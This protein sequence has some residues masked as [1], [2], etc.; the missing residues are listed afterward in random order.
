MTTP[1]LRVDP[2]LRILHRNGK[3]FAG[4]LSGSTGIRPLGTPDLVLLSMFLAPAAPGEAAER[5]LGGPRSSLL[6]VKPPLQHVVA[7]IA[8]L[9]HAG[10]LVEAAASAEADDRPA[11]TL[12]DCESRR[13][14]DGQAYF[15]L[16]TNFMLCPAA[17]GFAINASG[18]RREHVLGI[19]LALL[20]IS[21][22][23]GRSV[24]E[25]VAG[26]HGPG[27]P[28][29]RLQA[30][31]WLIAEGL[32][33][34]GRLAEAPVSAGDGRP[35]GE[36]RPPG[37]AAWEKMRPD[38]RIPVYF[39]PHMENHYPLALGM[40]ASALRAHAGGDLL[41]RFQ[42]L[43]ITYL[44]PEALINGP[45]RRFGPGVWLFS[46]YMWSLGVNLEI[47]TAIKRLDARNL[48]IH[49]GPST[50]NYE[51]A[52]RDFFARHGS[53][54]IAVHGEGEVA[55]GETFECLLRAADGAIRFD[56]HR[57]AQ[58]AG[59][60]YR[61]PGDAA[62]VRSTAPRRRLRQLDAL[63]SPYLEGEFDDYA[64]R[65]EAAIVET[66]RGCPFACTFCDWG[67][68][69]N[70][71]IAK[72]AHGR[73]RDEIE[74]IGRNKVRVLWI[75][76]AN[77]GMF[78]ADVE[79][80]AWVVEVKRRFGYPQEVVVNYTKNA[81][82]RLADIIRTFSTAGIVSQGI[83]SIQTTDA[84]TL[85]IIDRQNIKT[86][87]Y[88]E[89]LQV[90][91]DAGLPLST[92]L[93][94]GLPGATVESFARDLQRYIDVDV[95]VKAYPTQLLPNSPMAAPDYRARYRIEVDAQDFVVSCH[96]FTREDL[97]RMKA[98]NNVYVATEGYA[99]LRYVYRYL[100][101]DHGIPAMTLMQAINDLASTDPDRYPAI[102]WVA[103]YFAGNKCMPGGWR[104]FFDEIAAFVEASWSIGRTP[105][106]DVVLRANEAA[107]P[108]E[109]ITYPL[110]L[111]LSHDIVAWFRAHNV[112]GPV[113]APC[114][115]EYPPGRFVVDDPDGMV[116]IDHEFLQY[117]SHQYFWELHS[118]IS[119]TRSAAGLAA[120]VP[121]REPARMR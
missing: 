105:A 45:Y 30:V 56:P 43:P 60:S 96:S 88:D 86:A 14:P 19:E 74:W 69:T 109:A 76:D 33:V 114:L 49:G 1:L 47:S 29:V 41:Q 46:N 68:A 10:V 32:L 79:F 89:L 61:D 118:P 72:F 100:Q 82:T 103:K 98:L 12:G 67:S 93:M 63:P 8:Q 65:V 102:T 121:A 35:G 24:A 23:A 91:A 97:A 11:R 119:R 83:I 50:P 85:K 13:P 57:L 38:G 84:D 17:A 3:F 44:T 95:S 99:A 94:I 52:C 120:Q 36:A 70:G 26:L 113:D 110:V 62:T 115:A 80:A 22:A 81:T 71:K 101:W 58:V 92:D 25:A 9:R 37:A 64:G 66:N 54:D 77:F 4:R 5:L 27:E 75:A 6:P 104:S 15:R 34:P 21:F 7:A 107:M 28:A 2:T 87:K 106:F 116:S 112:R 16:S 42:L 55:A 73:V 31:G 20:L 108:D 78:P 53:V 40:I 51:Q 59:V 18:P 90:F 111:D 48:T 117:D 39:V